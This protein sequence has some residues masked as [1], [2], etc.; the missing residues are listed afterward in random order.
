[1]RSAQHLLETWESA[2]YFSP[3]PPA[4]SFPLIEGIFLEEKNHP[5]G[6][7]DSNLDNKSIR[8]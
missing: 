4:G 1:M 6:I 3:Q 8:C 7:R 2:P 5:K